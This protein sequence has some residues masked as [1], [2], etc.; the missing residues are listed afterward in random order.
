[1]LVQSTNKCLDIAG[2]DGHGNVGIWHCENGAKDQS[3]RYYENG[4]ILS[5]QT[6]KCLDV[7]GHGGTGNVGMYYCEDK[8]D[9]MWNR[10]TW[11]GHNDYFPF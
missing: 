1:M 2:H 3:W 10:Q 5:D 4:E 8:K 6:N 7:A 9:Q 11:N